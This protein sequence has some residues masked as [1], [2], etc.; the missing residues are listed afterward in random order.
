[1]YGGVGNGM[2]GHDFGGMACGWIVKKGGKV[3]VGGVLVEGAGSLA[4]CS[5]VVTSVESLSALGQRVA[6]LGE[7]IPS[8]SV[9]ELRS[10]FRS[11]THRCDRN[12]ESCKREL[13]WLYLTFHLSRL[14]TLALCWHKVGFVLWPH[15]AGWPPA[16]TDLQEW[17]LLFKSCRV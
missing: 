17:A 8:A 1:M 3:E 12:N 7:F 11:C 4:F 6:K 10:G 16:Y 13:M 14:L 2:V 5:S 15:P 9:L